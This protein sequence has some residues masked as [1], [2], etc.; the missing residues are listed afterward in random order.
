M[1]PQWS[2]DRTQR[3]SAESAA[4]LSDWGPLFPEPPSRL[5]SLLRLWRRGGLA[6]DLRGHAPL[7]R[8]GRG[9]SGSQRTEFIRG[10]L[11]ALSPWTDTGQ[12][13]GTADAGLR[14]PG[15]RTSEAPIA[16]LSRPYSQPEY[17][18]RGACVN[19]GFC[20]QGCRNGAKASMDVTYLP[21][22]V[23]AGAEIRAHC[24]VH[25]V[26]RNANGHIS[27][28]VSRDSAK[29]DR[30]ERRQRCKVAPHGG[31][32]DGGARSTPTQ[33]KRTEWLAKIHGSLATQVWG[34]FNKPVA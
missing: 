24:F 15:L 6:P 33:G 29:G 25:G 13:T 16:A 19:R 22:A 21:W 10:R 12:C 27:S 31:E 1:I 5:A 4:A 23:A 3:Y 30:V 20:H 7:L 8:G 9:L 28:V 26:E 11:T 32:W 2:S 14:C 17:G 18:E 34:T